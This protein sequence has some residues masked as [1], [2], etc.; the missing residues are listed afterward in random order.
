MTTAESIILQGMLGHINAAMWQPG[1]WDSLDIL[2]C[3]DQKK[4]IFSTSDKLNVY[5]LI[6]YTTRDI[7]QFEVL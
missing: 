5:P 4:W 3:N 2:F 6:T 1:L 7:F